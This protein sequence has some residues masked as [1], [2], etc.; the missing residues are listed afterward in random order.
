MISEQSLGNGGPEMKIKFIY[1]ICKS[2]LCTVRLHERISI[3]V[4]IAFGDL[5]HTRTQ[6]HTKLV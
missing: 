5:T 4:L 6:T 1:E 2:T 3:Y